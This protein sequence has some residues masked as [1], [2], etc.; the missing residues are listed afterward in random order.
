[1]TS[2]ERAASVQVSKAQADAATTKGRAVV[3]TFGILSETCNTLLRPNGALRVVMSA[4]NRTFSGVQRHRSCALPSASTSSASLSIRTSSGGRTFRTHLPSVRK[5]KASAGHK[6]SD[7][8]L[9]QS[10]GTTRAKVFKARK[11]LLVVRN[12]PRKEQQIKSPGLLRCT[13]STDELE[14]KLSRSVPIYL[15]L[16]RVW[17]ALMRELISCL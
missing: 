9:T 5:G 2:I 8:P 1:M 16:A 14:S 7:A 3:R 13:K 10:S 4:A 6:G 17:Q 11:R 12:G 15:H